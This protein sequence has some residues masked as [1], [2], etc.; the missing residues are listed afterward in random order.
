MH[1]EGDIGITELYL[2]FYPCTNISD[3]FPSHFFIFVGDK[4]NTVINSVR[5]KGRAESFWMIPIFDASKLCTDICKT[6]FA[7]F[8]P[9]F[10]HEDGLVQHRYFELFFLGMVNIFILQKISPERDRL[11]LF[12]IFAVIL[13]K[14]SAPTSSIFFLWKIWVIT[15]SESAANITWWV[16]WMRNRGLL[17]AIF[18]TFFIHF[19]LNQ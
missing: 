13:G 9:K 12:C 18:C 5:K 11:H 3:R 15:N 17:L 16:Y 19:P 6:I 7:F 2:S 1:W 8:K 10:Q 14:F 4:M